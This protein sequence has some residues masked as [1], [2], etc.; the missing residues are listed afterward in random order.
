MEKGQG[1]RP[2]P[3][4]TKLEKVDRAKPETDEVPLAAI[5]GG[6]ATRGREKKRQFQWP[7]LSVVSLAS[8]DEPDAKPKADESPVVATQS[9]SL[10]QIEEL[11][12]PCKKIIRANRI[13][14]VQRGDMSDMTNRPARKKKFADDLKSL[15]HKLAIAQFGKNILQGHHTAFGDTLNYETPPAPLKSGAVYICLS[16]DQCVSLVLGYFIL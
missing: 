15:A 14:E 2:V 9:F 1:P 10:P 12:F 8:F 6:P 7:L 4:P 16:R 5:C 11:Q 13:V 3:S